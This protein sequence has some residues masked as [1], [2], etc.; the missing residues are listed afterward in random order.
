MPVNI[1]DQCLDMVWAL[2]TQQGMVGDKVEGI[3]GVNTL[4]SSG[5]ASEAL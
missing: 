3:P 2:L 5:Q 1:A 4:L